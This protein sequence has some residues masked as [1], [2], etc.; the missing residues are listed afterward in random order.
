[1]QPFVLSVVVA[2]SLLSTLMG[3]SCMK[4]RL[5]YRIVYLCFSIRSLNSILSLRWLHTDNPDIIGKHLVCS[6]QFL[7]FCASRKGTVMARAGGCGLVSYGGTRW[8]PDRISKSICSS[9]LILCVSVR[10]GPKMCIGYLFFSYV[11]Y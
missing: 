7:P 3:Q 6:F 11:D 10:L 4:C 9:I 5:I 2:L 1:M 8:F